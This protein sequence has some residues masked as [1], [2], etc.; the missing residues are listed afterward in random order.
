MDIKV[1]IAIMIVAALIMLVN[2]FPSPL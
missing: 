2:Y 1:I